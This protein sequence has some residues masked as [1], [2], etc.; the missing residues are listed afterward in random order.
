[1]Y[2]QKYILYARKSS[3]DKNRQVTSIEDQIVEL[4]RLAKSKNIKIVKIIEESKSAKNP[5][6][7]F[8]ND[9]L[10]KI[11]SGYADGILC[12]KLDRLSRNAL[13]GGQISWMLQNNIIK[14]I[15]TIGSD[16]KPSDNVLMMAVELGMATQYVKDLKTNVKRGTR[17]KAERGWY[18]SPILPIGYKHNPLYQ[19]NES[20]EEIIPDIKSFP[21]VK[22]LWKLL[23]TKAYTVADLKREA[24]VLG[25][26]NGKN[27][28][29]SL[30]T[31]Y[32]MFNKEFYAGYFYWKDKDDIPTR[33]QGKHKT[34]I[35]LN[36]YIKAQKILGNTGVATRVRTYDFVYRGLMSCGE[37]NSHIT[38]EHIH[39]VI[40]SDCKYKFSIKTSQK[41]RRCGLLLKDM[42]A[43]SQIIKDYYRCTRKK[44]RCKQKSIEEKNIEEYMNSLL[45]KI[46]IKENFYQWAIETIKRM[47]VEINNEQ[48]ILPKLLHKKCLLE[49][50]LNG[51]INMRALNEI[52][53]AIFKEKS[54]GIKTELV[55]LDQK[56]SSEQLEKVDWK[57]VAL[58]RLKIA[59]HAFEKFKNM[60]PKDKKI[61]ISEIGSNLTLKDKKLDFITL[62]SLL[63]I[64]SIESEYLSKT[65]GFQ[66]K[67]NVEKYS[68]LGVLIPLNP[69]L[70][71]S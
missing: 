33:H 12:W 7:K 3:E 23:L 2:A 28:P 19:S 54:E 32:L 63:Y 70:L 40:C 62:K 48:S 5:G 45:S 61:I 59:R 35:S 58:K 10:S 66:P 68:D 8:F 69:S 46:T 60:S 41:C 43:P 71:A 25:L 21:I 22:K 14:H 51:L 38:A 18:P 27:Q 37:C 65:R 24:D 6:R 34:M 36:E 49:K 1:M 30:N 31:F 39:Q 17:Q 13:D 16:Y 9:L 53:G 4:K 50:Q 15:V 55:L 11:H 42:E 44:G 26:V 47:D 67:N 64:K 57:K 56:I 29:Y 52:D 20:T